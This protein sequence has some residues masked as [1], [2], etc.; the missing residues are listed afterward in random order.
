M[1]FYVHSINKEN[2]FTPYWNKQ[3]FLSLNSEPIPLVN[4]DIINT[5]DIMESGPCIH[6]DALRPASN[7]L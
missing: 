5:E 1:T 7:D 4:V 6:Y 2:M 3:V